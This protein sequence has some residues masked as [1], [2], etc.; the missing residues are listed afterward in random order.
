MRRTHISRG[1]RL[2]I[3]LALLAGMLLFASP[4]QTAKAAPILPT[5]QIYCFLNG[6]V[7]FQTTYFD[8]SGFS[9]K[10][11]FTSPSFP[12]GNGQTGRYVVKETT[13]ASPPSLWNIEETLQ[14]SGCS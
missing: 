3:G 13:L 14:V 2:S 10:V 6:M 4:T 1:I 8:P 5:G 7:F 12:L 9:G 11:L